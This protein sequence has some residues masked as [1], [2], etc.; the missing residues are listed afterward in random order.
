[1]VRTAVSLAPPTRRAALKPRRPPAEPPSPLS[2]RA[3][4]TLAEQLAGRFAERIR[5]RLLA[6][7][8]R[9]PSVR[10][11]ARRHG[12]SPATVVAAYDQLLARGLVEARP[13]RGFFV[14]ATHDDAARPASE[15]GRTRRR[16]RGSS[17]RTAPP[18]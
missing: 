9:L 8:A 18:R 6:P 12:V 7:G 16:R 10:E 3:D 14:R 4:T 13:Q 1:M 2:R 5:Q 17:C 15:R 11:C